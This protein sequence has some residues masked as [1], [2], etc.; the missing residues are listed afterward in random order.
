[1]INSVGE[2]EAGTASGINNAV[3]RTG[4]LLA[5][6]VLNIVLVDVLGSILERGLS[7]LNLPAGVQQAI[8]GQSIRLAGIEIPRGVSTTVNL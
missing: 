1:M 7:A 4:G 2:D 5:I 6:A 8:A 3:S